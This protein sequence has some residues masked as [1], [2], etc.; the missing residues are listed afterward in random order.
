METIN[1]GRRWV[2]NKIMSY[3]RKY[4][5]SISFENIQVEMLKGNCSFEELDINVKVLE[6]ELKLPFNIISGHIHNLKFELPWY[7]LLSNVEIKI[8]TIDNYGVKDGLKIPFSE[9]TFT[10]KD[11]KKKVLN[12]VRKYHK[13][14]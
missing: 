11:E 9:G 4:F 12:N 13:E 14:G 8:E 3:M 5:T 1:V 6:E 10:V 7:R 2:V